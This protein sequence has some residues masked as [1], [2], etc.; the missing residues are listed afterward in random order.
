MKQLFAAFL[1]H[2]RGSPT[3]LAECWRVV[4]RDTQV[5]GWTS[6]PA[7]LVLAGLTY[8]AATGL[9]TSGTETTDSLTVTTVDVTAFLDVTTE[10]DLLA[11][12]WNGA[13]VTMFQVNYRDIPATFDVTKLLVIKHGILGQVD[14]LRGRFRAELRDMLT[15]YDAPVGRE[16][17]ALCPWTLG[18]AVCSAGGLDINDFTFSGTV[19]SVGGSPRLT[20]SASALT[21]RNGAFRMGTIAFSTGDNA[22][23]PPMD[24]RL[25]HAKQFTMQRPLPFAVQVGDD[26]D[27]VLG[28]D[29][30]FNTCKNVFNNAGQH[31]GF[32][33]LPGIDKL[34]QSDTELRRRPPGPP[35]PDLNPENTPGTVLAGD[36]NDR[37]GDTGE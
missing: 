19:S 9:D 17:T 31:A 36:E 8:T 27:V 10:A 22:G 33:D 7:D 37:G 1:N 16:Y 14:V 21:Q 5:F 24:I 29:K 20:F 6:H 34:V 28:D 15:Y 25:W 4:R 11:G 35:V 30:T 26:F 32:R 18:D 23:F 3:T 2:L 13:V 12:V